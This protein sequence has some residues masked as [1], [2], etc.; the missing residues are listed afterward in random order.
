M[1]VKQK[2][3]RQ[4]LAGGQLGY[5]LRANYGNNMQRNNAQATDFYAYN[6]SVLVQ[7]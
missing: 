6:M 2:Y 1:N 3:G 4:A 5:K 7:R